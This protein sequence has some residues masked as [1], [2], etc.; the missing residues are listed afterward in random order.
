MSDVAPLGAPRQN[1]IIST[2]SEELDKKIGGGLPRGSL[3][4]IEGHSDAGKSVLAEQFAW[5]ALQGGLRVAFYSTENTIR[6][7]L[8][9]SAS[10]GA[11]LSDYYLLGRLKVIPLQLPKDPVEPALV[12]SELYAHLR[13]QNNYDVVVVDSLTGALARANAEAGLE[14]FVF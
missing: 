9:Q 7:L 4:L 14:F 8:K 11:D 6:N 2:G 1:T 12:L 13:S 5:G 10:L 3:T